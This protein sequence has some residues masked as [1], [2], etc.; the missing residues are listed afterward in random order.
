MCKIIDI[1]V[2]RDSRVSEKEREKVEKF[3]DLKREIARIW[4]MRNVEVITV[5]VG[6]LGTIKKP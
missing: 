2:P 5:V 3:H 1:A 6:A 4:S